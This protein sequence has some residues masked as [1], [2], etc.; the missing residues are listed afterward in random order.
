[1]RFY[2]IED[3]SGIS[4]HHQQRLAE[5]LTKQCPVSN[6]F[7]WNILHRLNIL[8]FFFIVGPEHYAC[9]ALYARKFASL[10]IQKFLKEEK[11]K[12]NKETNPATGE[13][14]WGNDPLVAAII[15]EIAASLATAAPSRGER[16]KHGQDSC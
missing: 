16:P 10:F 2:V 8:S 14:N 3:T 15:A 9:S 11:E 4:P 1:M 6:F 5:Y 12:E 13:T 7:S